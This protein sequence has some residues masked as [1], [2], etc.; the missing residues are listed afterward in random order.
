M[1][2]RLLALLLALT[3]LVSALP[4]ALAAKPSYVALGDSIAAGYGLPDYTG[5]G[6]APASS[7]ASLVADA[8]GCDL[9][10]LGVSGSDTEA[11]LASLTSDPTYISAVSGADYIT[12][13]I[14]SNDLLVKAL[15]LLMAHYG[16]TDLQDLAGASAILGDVSTVSGAIAAV[17]ALNDYLI[18]DEIVS[19]MEASVA[20]Y[21][22][23]WDAILLRVRE[24]NPDA[25]VVVTSYYNPYSMF[26]VDLSTMGLNLTI[27]T[28]TQKWLDEM[29]AWLYTSPCYG[30]IYT[31]AEVG[32][33]STNVSID[34]TTIV[35]AAMAGSASSGLSSLKESISLDPHP[36]TEGHAF[37]ARQLL[38]KLSPASF[39]DVAEDAWYASV[40]CYA[41]DEGLVLGY[42][43]GTFRPENNM[44]VAEYLT[45]MYR[46]AAECSSIIPQKATTGTSWMDAAKF[47]NGD[48]LD[49]L[50]TESELAATMT[51]YQM[52]VITRGVLKFVAR[53]TLREPQVRGTHGFSDV[54]AADPYY[55]AVSYL[56]SVYGIDGYA[57]SDG[58]YTFRGSQNI[59]R[60][61]VAQVVYNIMTLSL[62]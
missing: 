25:V 62:A 55:E 46:Y 35:S 8:L 17:Q 20:Q 47:I 56:E 7:Y 10:N 42:D 11:L 1:K 30:T 4:A 6:S 50:F 21:K 38:K 14:G 28:L 36:D 57:E 9:T 41:A 52:A 53:I 29:N 48:M 26:S 13:S 58:T 16:I 59:R 23:N 18:S 34:F 39:S 45:I 44:T 54:S 61:E 49:N 37:I 40:V 24:L 19:I 51:R 32:E 31:V 2:K 22:I 33:V 15:R 43:D 27:G 60:C 5:D 12:L 3:L